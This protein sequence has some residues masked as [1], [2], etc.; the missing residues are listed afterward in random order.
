MRIDRVSVF[1]VVSP[2]VRAVFA[3]VFL[4]FDGLEFYNAIT[5]RRKAM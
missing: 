4:P 2:E 5:E 1:R 3:F